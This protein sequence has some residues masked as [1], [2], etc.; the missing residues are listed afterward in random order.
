MVSVCVC[1]EGGGG[2]DPMVGSSSLTMLV[3]SSGTKWLWMWMHLFIGG[4]SLI[5]PRGRALT[6]MRLG[7]KTYHIFCFSCGRLGYSGLVQHREPE[8]QRVMYHLERGCSLMMNKKG[9]LQVNI[10]AQKSS[11]LGKNRSRT[12]IRIL[13]MLMMRWHPLK[14]IMEAKF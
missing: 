9:L 14:T 11:M 8:M 6:F 12:V 7:M 1:G 13:A 3:V 4:S 2:H 10:W 5:R